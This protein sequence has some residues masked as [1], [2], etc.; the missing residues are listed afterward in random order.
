[1]TASQLIVVRA[2]ELDSVQLGGLERIY[3]EAFPPSLRVPLAELA[4]PSPRDRLL[5]A[6][7]AGEP[8]GFASLRLLHDGG[9]VFLRYCAVAAARRRAGLGLLFWRQ[10]RQA[11][12]GGGWPA[13]IAF[14]VEDPAH[15]DGDTGE[16]AIRH[17]RIGFWR[18]CGAIELPVPSYVMPALTALGEPEPMVLMAFDPQQRALSSADLSDLV[19]AIFTRHYGLDRQH[20]LVRAALD[21]IGTGRG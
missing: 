4:T 2:A 17:G 15:A 5:V 20:L 6:L 10:L 18:N 14:E 16:Q 19:C 21:S 13:R 3:R 1:M 9:W 12:A 8:V 7:E 11:V